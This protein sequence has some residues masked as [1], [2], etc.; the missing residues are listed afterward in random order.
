[1]P[2]PT[3]RIAFPRSLPV[4]RSLFCSLNP[5]ALT[6]SRSCPPPTVF[7]IYLELPKVKSRVPR[8]GQALQPALLPTVCPGT[9]PATIPT[10]RGAAWGLSP[11]PPRPCRDCPHS[12]R[13]AQRLSRG[14]A[15]AGTG[16]A[17]DRPAQ[18]LSRA[19][20]GDTPLARRLSRAGRAAGTLPSRGACPAAGKVASGEQRS[21]CEQKSR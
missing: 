15:R 13:P 17:I 16:A 19:G 18:R 5:P 6:R 1:M 8:A 21:G 2:H 14:S 4:P 10:P 9:G 7:A 11:F 3:G 12:R 20:T